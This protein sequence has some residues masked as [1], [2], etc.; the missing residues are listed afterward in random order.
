MPDELPPI[1][2][3]P[4]RLR[5]FAVWRW[6][7]WQSVVFILL[8]FAAY[9]L[10]FGPVIWLLDRNLLPNWAARPL[11]DIYR[12]L[13]LAME[14]GWDFGIA[15]TYANWFTVPPPYDYLPDGPVT[16]EVQP[17]PRNWRED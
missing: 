10:S 15:K 9:P 7:W 13:A 6:K 1:D 5:W 14:W 2:P 8:L 17:A 16:N 4:P 12:P 3:L 11:G